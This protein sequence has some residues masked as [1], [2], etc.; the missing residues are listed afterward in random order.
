MYHGSE[1]FAQRNA[2]AIQKHRITGA[3]GPASFSSADILT[4]SMTLTRQCSDST[5][6]QIGAV[7]VSKLTFTLIREIGINARDFVGQKV[8]INFGLLLDEDSNTYEY[9]TLGEFYIVEANVT[10]AG[11]VITCYDAMANFEK[12]LPDNFVTSGTVYSITNNICNICGVD[13]GMTQAQAEALPNGTT[14][15]GLY[16]PNDC[17]TYRDVI[18][19]LSSTIGGFA[20]IDRNGRLIYQTYPTTTIPGDPITFDRRL[21]DASFSDYITDFGAATFTDADGNTE[22]IGSPGIGVTYQVGFNPFLQYGTEDTKMNMMRAITTAIINIKYMPYK[23]TIM[24]APIYDLGDSLYFSD[25]IA[26]GRAWNGIIHK[27]TYTPGKGTT[28]EGFGANPALQNLSRGKQ[29]ATRAA[30]QAAQ[31]SEMVMKRYENPVAAVVGSEPEQVVQ[32]DFVTTKPTEV[33]IWHE[34]QIET[35]LSSGSDAMTIEAVYYMDDIEMTRKPIETFTDDAMHLLD[36]HFEMPVEDVGSHRWEVYLETSGG[37]ATIREKDVLALLKGQGIS[38]AD[39]WTGVIILDDDVTVYDIEM[40]IQEITAAVVVGLYDPEYIQISD[41]VGP[42]QIEM[43]TQSV[44]ES[45]NIVL[46]QFHFAIVSENSEFY[47]TDETGLYHLV[48]E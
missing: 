41:T 1:L 15:I 20:T 4:G 33:E 43:E 32:I 31:I 10:K 13:F 19:W 18:Y 46:Q 28:L 45:V 29:D 14:T 40:T 47:I 36:L 3:I 42:V 6:S 25:G 5:D 17:K 39:A 21:N 48:S 38:K 9:F 22:T 35:E 2:R 8:T 27:I 30:Q 16:T 23:V 11:N 34:I 26:D 44:T 7:F 24:S 12:V 37:T